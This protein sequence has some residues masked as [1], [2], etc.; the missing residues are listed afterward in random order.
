MI[1]W[2]TPGWAQPKGRVP[3]NRT[4]PEAINEEVGERMLESLRSA[5]LGGDYALIVQLR[6][7]PRRGEDRYFHGRF[8]GRREG[9]ANLLRLRLRPAEVDPPGSF[10]LLLHGLPVGQTWVS[11]K[12]APARLLEPSDWME[13]LFGL[14]VFSAFELQ[15]DFL[16]WE[17]AVYEGPERLLGR[18]AHRFLL[19][20]PDQL[21]NFPIAAV[22]LS[23]DEKFF[24]PLAA[25]FLDETGEI[26][27]SLKVASFKKIG[28]QW[29]VNRID[30]VDQ[31]SG[32]RTR[33]EITAAAL[34][35]RLPDD[36]FLPAK[37][38]LPESPVP[39]EA[40]TFF[41]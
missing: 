36:F 10:Q 7:M 12:F 35:Y 5:H 17:E 15:M 1:L 40:F 13:P 37:L 33:L 32:D 39:F 23:V 14:T 29:I 31:R 22:R 27:K 2:L 9:E 20:P 25:E 6:H 21:E 11:E 19:Y 34:D 26:L 30:L 38:S 4:T 41:R 16:R 8:W 3:P 18:P 24:A 28:E